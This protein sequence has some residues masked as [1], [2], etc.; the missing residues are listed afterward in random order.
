MI[1]KSDAI[2]ELAAALSKAQSKLSHVKKDRTARIRMKAGGEYSYNYAD[3]G[4]TWDAGRAALTDNGLSVSQLPSFDS[5][6]LM[7]D[8]I[9]MHASGQ[10]ISSQ[11]RTRADEM[12]VKSIGSAITYLRRYAFAAIIGLVADEDDDGSAPNPKADP[13]D[14]PHNEEGEKPAASG[15]G[16]KASDKQI[17]MLFAIWNKGG[18]DGKLTEWIATSFG[19]GIDD[20]SIAQA[21]EAI[22]T[23]QPDKA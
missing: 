13:R 14:Q 4:S 2:N 20:L 23:L 15:K 18:F 19:C 17:K 12:D 7:L 5:G 1:D 8:T 6:W 11:M 22:S 3:L 21:S 10:Y 16:N 9:L